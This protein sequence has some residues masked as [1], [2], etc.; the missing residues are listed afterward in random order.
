MKQGNA[1]IPRRKPQVLLSTPL[2]A[3]CLCCKLHPVKAHIAEQHQQQHVAL[4]GG[5]HKA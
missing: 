3:I 4:L 1:S 5:Q 2:S